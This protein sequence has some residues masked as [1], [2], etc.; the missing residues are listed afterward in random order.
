MAEDARCGGRSAT[1]YQLMRPAIYEGDM[2][3][4]FLA[5]DKLT[6]ETVVVKAYKKRLMNGLDRFALDREIKI[7][8]SLQHQH[9]VQLLTWFEDKEQVYLVQEHAARGDLFGVVRSDGPRS[10]YCDEAVTARE[11]IVP[12]VLAVAY[13]HSNGIAHR[14][15]K[16]ENILLATDGSLRLADF[17]LSIDF[18]EERPVSRVGTLDYMA[19]EVFLCPP[20]H[21]PLENKHDRTL[22]YSSKVDVWAIGVLA[23][24]LLT[25]A[26]PF[27]SGGSL[28]EHA[29]AVLYDELSFPVTMSVAA[30]AFI[31]GA[32]KKDARERPVAAALLKCPWLAP[33]VDTAAV[34]L[35]LSSTSGGG[36]NSGG[37]ASAQPSPRSHGG[38]SGGNSSTTGISSSL[39][40][41]GSCAG[42]GGSIAGNGGTD[43]MH[44]AL[45]RGEHWERRVS[46]LVSPQLPSGGDNAVLEREVHGSND[47]NDGGDHELQVVAG[48]GLCPPSR[49]G[50]PDRPSAPGCLLTPG[51]PAQQQPPPP[52][53]QQQQQQPGA[54]PFTGKTSHDSDKAVVTLPHGQFGHLSGDGD[55]LDTG[56]HAMGLEGSFQM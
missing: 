29:N 1:D 56:I 26:S 23:Y 31:R 55:A 38:S 19:P 46:D 14:D 27:A 12:L 35:L 5:K 11:V 33:H 4:V 39:S 47:G 51:L 41:D 48:L 49:P 50:R 2:S 16:P 36:G 52:P 7:H 18:N 22:V 43:A 8:G 25:G 42:R 40:S 6:G 15:I 21:S 34:E 32:L 3:E 9:V 28:D 45:Q 44:H 53:P 20:K 37:E 54:C 30:K 10:R 13:L 17:G 24:E